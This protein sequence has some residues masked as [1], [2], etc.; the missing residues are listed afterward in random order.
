MFPEFFVKRKTA[1]AILLQKEFIKSKFNKKIP[2]S[3]LPGLQ[4]AK[5]NHDLQV[6]SLA[7][8]DFKNVDFNFNTEKILLTNTITIENYIA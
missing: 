6:N 8:V 5:I 4:N 3:A 7:E 2:Q 1:R